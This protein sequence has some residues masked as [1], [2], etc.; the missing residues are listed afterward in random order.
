MCVRVRACS[1]L[2]KPMEAYA[3]QSGVKSG[4]HS[5][6]KKKLTSIS[7]SF[8]F[9]YNLSVSLSQTLRLQAIFSGPWHPKI[10]LCSITIYEISIH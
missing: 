3:E 6:Q 4:T 2:P 10:G 7:V 9:F 8:L 5:A 1:C